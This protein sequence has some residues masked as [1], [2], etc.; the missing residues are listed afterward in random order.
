M[1]QQERTVAFE[2][3]KTHEAIPGIMSICT[4]PTCKLTHEWSVY[5]RPQR[6]GKSEGPAEWVSDHRDRAEAIL[7]ALS[8]GRNHSVVLASYDGEQDDYV[9]TNYFNAEGKVIERL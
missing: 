8:Y 7:A 9:K 3:D 6:D 4:D 1:S 5:E 2:V